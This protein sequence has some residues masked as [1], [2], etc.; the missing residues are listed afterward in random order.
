MVHLFQLLKFYF[1]EKLG[2]SS[3]VKLEECKK[4]GNAEL[5]GEKKAKKKEE[6]REKREAAIKGGRNVDNEIDL[7]LVPFKI[8]NGP[9][10]SPENIRSNISASSNIYPIHLYNES[11]KKC[12]EFIGHKIEC[13]YR[14][15]DLKWIYMFYILY[16]RRKLPV[17][18]SI[19]VIPTKDKEQANEKSIIINF[20]KGT[21]GKIKYSYLE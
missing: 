15:K 2:P 9:S 19:D 3:N 20:V 13:Y 11:A 16:N 6:R 12:D 4:E 17:V 5:K 8:K 18:V 14:E 10:D 1:Q 21:G 7:N